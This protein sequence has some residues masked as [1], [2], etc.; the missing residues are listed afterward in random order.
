MVSWSGNPLGTKPI[1]Q[2]TYRGLVTGLYRRSSIEIHEMVHFSIKSLV[3]ETFVRRYCLPR[4]PPAN[5]PKPEAMAPPV[6]TGRYNKQLVYRYNWAYF[7][8]N[9]RSQTMI[10][11]FLAKLYHH[12]CNPKDVPSFPTNEEYGAHCTWPE[13]KPFFWEGMEAPMKHDGEEDE[14]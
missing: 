10:H 1:T 3:D 11:D 6:G 5:Q 13:D 8:A 7:D 12:Q 4:I 9:R 2:L 14:A